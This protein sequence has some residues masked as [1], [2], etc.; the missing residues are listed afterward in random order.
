MA[1][2]KERN[3]KLAAGRDDDDRDDER[4]DDSLD[5]DN[6]SKVRRAAERGHEEGVTVELEDE[7]KDKSP[8]DDDDEPHL[9]RADKKR[10]RGRGFA[11]E[12]DEFAN[13]LQDSRER[14]ARLLAILDSVAKRPGET[15]PA[16]GEEKTPEQVELD[17]VNA[18]LRLLAAKA[19]AYGDKMTAAQEEELAAEADKLQFQKQKLITRI[20]LKESG[21]GGGERGGISDQE[22][23]RLVQDAQFAQVREEFED[24]YT[25][26]PRRNGAYPALRWAKGRL[27]QLIADSQEGV[28]TMRLMRQAL[29]DAAV[30][31][32]MR[33]ETSE[34]HKRKFVSTSRGGG[35]GGDEKKVTLTP[36]QVRLGNAR[37]SHIKDQKARL[38]A[39]AKSIKERAAKAQ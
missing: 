33:R 36:A 15:K 22:R 31:Y 26:D 28:F 12:R 17:G 1:T 7:D 4:D 5:G 20:T 32:G 21:G 3:A 38:Q 34:G 11:Q 6:I 2:A 23:Q 30:K 13:M 14:E 37:F 24:V 29:R 9:S 35:G 39:I 16:V 27:E 25:H 19:R 10:A 18:N 8:D